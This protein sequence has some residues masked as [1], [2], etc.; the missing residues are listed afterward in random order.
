MNFEL[1]C[2]D[3]NGIAHIITSGDSDSENYCEIVLN[4]RINGF[5][6]LPKEFNDK[7]LEIYGRAI[8]TNFTGF[9]KFING[10]LH[11]KCG[12]D[13]FQADHKIEVLG[14][15]CLSINISTLKTLQN[16][17]KFEPSAKLDFVSKDKGYIR[18]FLHTAFQESKIK[19]FDGENP[20][21]LITL[22]KNSNILNESNI[23]DF[24][25]SIV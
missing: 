4:G 1:D 14:N 20:E 15:H 21:D 3:E 25:D 18:A 12:I 24:L 5:S 8:I 9:F 19:D 16:F 23:I 6:G 2:V 11:I 10:D 22:L 7:D 13:S 17:P